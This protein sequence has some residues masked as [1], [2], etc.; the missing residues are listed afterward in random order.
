MGMSRPIKEQRE[1]GSRWKEQQV[2]RSEGRK[3]H[4]VLRGLWDQQ[5]LLEK[6]RWVSP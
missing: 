4:G 5:K 1:D 6:D 2:Q 3:R